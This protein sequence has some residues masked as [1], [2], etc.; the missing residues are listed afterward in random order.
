MTLDLQAIKE[1]LDKKLTLEG[2]YLNN[3]GNLVLY[4]SKGS[5]EPTLE[6]QPIDL[7]DLAVAYRA[8]YYAGHGD[9]YISLDPSPYPEQVNVNFGGRLADT[10]MGWVVLRS[11]MRFKTLGEGFDPVTTNDLRAEIRTALPD[12][13][14]QTERKITSREEIP[15]LE[16]T[17]FW[18]HPN[19]VN[20]FTNSVN[21]IMKIDSPRFTGQAVREDPELGNTTVSS[22]ITPSWTK[23]TLAH[24][25]KNYDVFAKLFPELHELDDVGRLLVLF[26]WL[27]QQKIALD[28]DALLDVELPKFSTPRRKP[29]LLAGYNA[30]NMRFTSDNLSQFSEEWL[31]K[32]SYYSKAEVRTH[33]VKYC[34]D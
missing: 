22:E 18:F 29:Q 25:N 19:S 13:K 28:L 6:G 2:A 23:D 5:T 32:R 7:S 34:I 3:E 11:D 12:F 30:I 9:A 26:S 4:G 8:V 10:R 31:S 15:K 33:F 24:L 21:K 16:Y 17:R 14:T 27:K 20:I 1:F